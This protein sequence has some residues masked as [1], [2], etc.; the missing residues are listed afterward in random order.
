M[1]KDDRRD[2]VEQLLDA[3]DPLWYDDDEWAEWYLNLTRSKNIQSPRGLAHGICPVCWRDI[4]F[5]QSRG[6][7]LASVPHTTYRGVKCPGV[8][9]D[10]FRLGGPSLRVPMQELARF[11]A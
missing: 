11:V 5:S 4:A 6:K 10:G 1:T 8:R 2:F 7:P 3:Q 9:I